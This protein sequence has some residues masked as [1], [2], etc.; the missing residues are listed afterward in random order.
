MKFSEAWLR[1]WVDPPLD[2]PAL[3]N[4]LTMAGLEVASAEPVAPNLT[5]LIVAKVESVAPHPTAQL[6]TCQVTDGAISRQVVC[7]ASNVRPGLVSALALPGAV[8]PNGMHI[9]AA[10]IRGVQSSGML[11]S[12]AELGLGEDADGILDLGDGHPPGGDLSQALALDDVCIELDLTPNRGDCLGMLGLARELGV[13]NALPVRQRKARPV[14]TQI[15]AVFPV[16]LE[17]PQGCPRYLGRVI[18]GL[19]ARAQTPFWMQERLRRCGMR[20]LGPVV[21]VTNYVMLELGQPLHAFDLA[22]LSRGITVRFAA[23]GEALTLL[24]GRKIE[25][26]PAV[27]VI[28][29]GAGPVAIAGVMGG[30]R[31]GVQTGTVDAFLECAYFDPQTIAGTAHRFALHTD[32]SHRYERG[33]DYNLPAAALERATEL[34]L[35]IVGG[36]PGP[37]QAAEAPAQLPKER[38]VSLRQRR[39]RELSGVDID[40]QQVDTLLGRLAS[41]WRTARKLRRT[42]WPGPSLPHP[43]AS[44]SKSRRTWWRKSAAFTA[45]TTS[46]T[47]CHPPPSPCSQAPCSK[48]ASG[49]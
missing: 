23:A 40:A 27:L 34:L 4:Q 19:D 48:A 35:N 49:T 9:E 10:D 25:L 6:S 2:R 22:A 20:S 5:G 42:G 30:E 44:T 15:D 13:L 1:E 33:V 32:A 24:D 12:A 31:S 36:R 21:D 47:S 38:R 11:C 18:R 37:L 26:D 7:G 14:P 29:D 39:L 17:A 28:A 46:P 3:L 8:L 43:I 41:P 16:A 45:T